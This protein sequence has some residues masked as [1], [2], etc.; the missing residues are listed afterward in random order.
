VRAGNGQ[1]G[2]AIRGELYRVDEELL[3]AL[4]R[5]E[6]VPAEYVRETIRLAD[7]G[8]AQ[9]YIYALPFSGLML[10]GAEWVK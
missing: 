3:A 5:F 8:V 7:G 10:C 2:L 9:T 1:A 4:D 6:G